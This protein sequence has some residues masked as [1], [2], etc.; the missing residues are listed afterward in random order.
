MKNK[1]LFGLLL[2]TMVIGFGFTS[3]EKDD[4]SEGIEFRMRNSDYGG[5]GISILQVDN[6]FSVNQY[7][8]YVSW[9]VN[10]GISESNNFYVRSI[11]N[12]NIGYNWPPQD[13]SIACVGN[14]S[15][16]RRINR[17]SESGWT[18]VV[19]VKPGNGY[20]ICHKCEGDSSFC[21]YARVYVEDWIEGTSGGIIGAV[22]RYQ[23]NWKIED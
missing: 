14:V 6:E 15:N 16:I 19:S 11:V 9:W 12:S 10:L 1:Y 22:I 7:R 13:C 8:Y 17:I 18:D 23:D 20:I 4:G 2:M 3:C 5:D 21:R